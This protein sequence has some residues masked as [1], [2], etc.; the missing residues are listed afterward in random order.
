MWSEEG[1]II[2]VARNGKMADMTRKGKYNG[3]GWKRVI[4]RMWPEEGNI[5]DMARRG[6][7]K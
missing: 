6:E 7:H 2:D 5:T 4:Q 1:N 3:C